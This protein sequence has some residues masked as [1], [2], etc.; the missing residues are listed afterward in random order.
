MASSSAT[1]EGI[2]SALDRL[3]AHAASLPPKSDMSFH[4]TLD[5][6]FA[7]SVDGTSSDLLSLTEKLLTLV[8]GDLST[9]KPGVKGKGRSKLVDEQD[10]IEGFRR[11]VGNVIDG[12]LEDAVSDYLHQNWVN[13][14][15]VGRILD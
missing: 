5:R 4:R 3:T 11:S 9:A 12:L 8:Q 15:D 6:K 14:I 2:T 7:K 10:A 13:D 1:L